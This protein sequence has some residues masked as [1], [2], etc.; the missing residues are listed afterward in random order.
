[1]FII[2]NETEKKTTL[3]WIENFKK[4]I[5]EVNNSNADNLIKQ[6]QINGYKIQ[7]ADLEKQLEKYEELKKGNL[8]LPEDLSFSNLLGYLTKIRISKGISQAE[9]ARMIGVSRQQISRYELQD[10]Q[11]A[12]LERVNQILNVLRLKISI[13]L[14]DVA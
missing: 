12:S 2:K 3:E 4:A 8:K 6:A 7:I 9:L 13:S 11:G 10:Y 5:E 1:M 14:Q